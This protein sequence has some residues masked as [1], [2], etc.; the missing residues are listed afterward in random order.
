MQ[1][2]VYISTQMHIKPQNKNGSSKTETSRKITGSR[3]RCKER[4]FQK[5]LVSLRSA[6]EKKRVEKL[7]VRAA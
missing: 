4:A 7:F 2:S 5:K 3:Y 1:I 6:Q